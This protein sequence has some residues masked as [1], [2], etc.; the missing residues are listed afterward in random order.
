MR[1]RAKTCSKTDSKLKPGWAALQEALPE[2]CKLLATGGNSGRAPGETM[3][4]QQQKHQAERT[5]LLSSLVA[6]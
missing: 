2:E 1:K 6:A 5:L 3:T 4:V